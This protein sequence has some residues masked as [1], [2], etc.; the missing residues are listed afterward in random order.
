M[1]EGRRLGKSDLEISPLGLGCWQFSGGKGLVGGFWEALQQDQV[2]SIVRVALEGRV[3]WF[4]TAEAYGGGHSE[5]ALV[6]ALRA[7][8]VVPGEVLIATKWWP[9]FRWA[10]NLLRSIEER[11]EQLGGYPIDLYQ[12]HGPFSFSGIR[13]EM[14]AM[15]RLVKSGKIR[16][17][18]VSNYPAR[19]MERAHRHL[20]REGVP[21]VANQIHYSL[22]AR[23]P[24]VNGVLETAKRLGITI[25]A[26]SPLAQGILTGRHHRDPKLIHTR[27]GPRKRMAAFQRKGLER[28]RP[29]VEALEEIGEALGATP[30]QVALNWVLTF[31]GKT[32]VAIPGAS[33]PSQMDENLGALTFTLEREDLARLDQLSRP[34]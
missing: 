5:R 8:G 31:H 29:L 3:N 24:D 26:Y 28:T 9:A 20:A 14:A 34:G 25:I 30:A 33:H 10:G 23:R 12:I 17:V 4:D 22:L 18:G 11:L 2:R 1:M 32:V 6:E 15:A 27:P 21:L 19:M 16:T 13:A 7:L